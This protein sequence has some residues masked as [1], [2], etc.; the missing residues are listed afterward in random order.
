MN[1]FYKSLLVILAIVMMAG[2]LAACGSKTQ[3]SSP[4]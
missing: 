4:G 2:M 1:K 3:V